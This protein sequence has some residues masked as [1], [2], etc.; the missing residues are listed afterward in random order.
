MMG[1]NGAL[2]TELEVLHCDQQCTTATDGLVDIVIHM[3]ICICLY[4]RIQ[5]SFH[6]L[7]FNNDT[8][9]TDMSLQLIGSCH[10]TGIISASC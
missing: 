2:K 1:K 10:Y 7:Y 6:S 8:F 3:H 4:N 9:G 5:L